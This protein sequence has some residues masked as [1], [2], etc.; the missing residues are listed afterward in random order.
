MIMNAGEIFDDFDEDASKFLNM[1]EQHLPGKNIYVDLYIDELK[2]EMEQE[3]IPIQKLDA[4]LEI[5]KNHLIVEHHTEGGLPWIIIHPL[6]TREVQHALK[7]KTCPKC[8]KRILTTKI[9]SYC[10]SPDCDYELNET[11]APT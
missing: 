6:R 5:M 7:S 10:P 11:K 1:L 2:K 3:D 8:S 9:V 4:L